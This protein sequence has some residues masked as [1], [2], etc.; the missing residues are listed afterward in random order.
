MASEIIFDGKKFISS[1]V[2]STRTGYAGDYISQLCRSG[3]IDCKMVGR[4]WHV[5]EEDLLAHKARNLNCDP[6]KAERLNGKNISEDISVMHPQSPRPFPDWMTGTEVPIPIASVVSV[7]AVDA[8][9]MPKIASSMSRLQISVPAK[10]ISTGFFSRVAT[11]ALSVVVV[12]G[13]YFFV[14]GDLPKRMTTFA[15]EEFSDLSSTLALLS[16]PHTRASV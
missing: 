6:R 15:Q 8:F 1:G 9:S 3:K 11:F 10:L 13:G 7:D 14:N 16:D 5:C 12:F 2:A 4:S